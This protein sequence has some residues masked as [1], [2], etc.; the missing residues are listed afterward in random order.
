M[1]HRIGSLIPSSILQ[2]QFLQVYFI[3]DEEAQIERRTE[4]VQSVDKNIVKKLQRVFHDHNILVHE[5]KTARD[6]MINDNNFKV[7]IHPDRVPRGQH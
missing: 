5:F 6:R 3:G 1:Y 2:P 7:V 4:C